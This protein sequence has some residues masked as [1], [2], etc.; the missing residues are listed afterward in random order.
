MPDAELALAVRVLEVPTLLL[1]IFEV[2]SVVALAL[3]DDVVVVAALPM[4][5][6]RRTPR[7]KSVTFISLDQE[8]IRIST[9]YREHK[10]RNIHTFYSKV[11]GTR[12]SY[13]DHQFR[14]VILILW[15]ACLARVLGTI[16][17]ILD[18]RRV[19]DASVRVFISPPP[20]I[21][22]KVNLV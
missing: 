14:L 9:N 6:W 2:L 11:W 3:V 5:H 17:T 15:V 16:E 7:Y 21:P 1:A 22:I 4:V 10:L 12:R 20:Q 8:N 13:Y 19:A 18:Q